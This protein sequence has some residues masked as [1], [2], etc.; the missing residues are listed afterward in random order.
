MPSRSADSI[1]RD[2]IE[3]KLEEIR[4]RVEPATDQAKGV[5]VAIGILAASGLVT[6]AY[7]IGRRRGRRRQAVVEIRRV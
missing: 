5:G 2:Q 3:A 4:G 1:S 6:A 7:L